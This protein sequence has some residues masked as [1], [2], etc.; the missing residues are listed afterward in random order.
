M[1]RLVAIVTTVGLV[2]ALLPSTTLAATADQKLCAQ[3][4]ACWY[5]ANAQCLISGPA[6]TGPLL[7]PFFP[8]VSDTKDLVTRI[9]AY[10]KDTQPDSPFASVVPQL[11]QLGQQYNVNPG[12]MIGDAQNETS[13]GTAGFGRPP[14]NNPYD[15]RGNGPGGFAAYPTF[16]DGIEAYYK[17][18]SSGDYLGPPTSMT[19]I[20]QIEMKATPFGD[21]ANN[22]VAKTQQI[23]QTMQKILG[24]ITTTGDSNAIA[25]VSSCGA[26]STSA[27][28]LG[29]DLSGAH[30]MVS[31]DQGDPQWASHPYGAGKTPIGQSGCGPTSMAMVAAT[32]TGNNSITPVTIADRYGAKYHGTDGTDWSVFPVFAA[33]YGLKESDLGT[34]LQAAAN[35]IRQGGLVIISVAPGYFTSTGHLMV[36]RAVTPDGTGFYL[37]DPNGK[38]HNGDSETR[39]F[40]AGFLLGQGNMQNLWGFSK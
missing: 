16:T 15:I 30:A 39:A 10:L 2:M 1:K 7:G 38:G 3:Y 31:Y 37:A 9:Q 28:A 19:T 32:L 4:G 25:P 14:Q 6:G 22:P 8:K 35:I 17:Q 36:I 34:N 12:F 11:V 20:L 29:W 24:G 40:T 18:I 26:G 21:G 33:D 27:G 23:V 5:D 13:L